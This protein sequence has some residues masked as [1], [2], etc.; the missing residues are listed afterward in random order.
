MTSNATYKLEVDIAFIK[1]EIIRLGHEWRESK[2]LGLRMSARFQQD[3]IA[4]LSCEL[5][6]LMDKLEAI[7]EA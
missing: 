5:T 2:R 7:V 4:H 1:R 6:K 3:R